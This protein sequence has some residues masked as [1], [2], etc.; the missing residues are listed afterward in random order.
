VIRLAQFSLA[1]FFAL[2][3]APASASLTERDDVRHFI[4]EMAERHGFDRSTLTD[5][6]STAEIK[7]NILEAIARPAEAKPWHQYRPI[8]LTENR[9]REGVKFWQ[10]HADVLAR[11][12]RE[13]GVAAQVIVAIIGVETFYGRHSG[14]HRVLDALSTLAFGYP[15]R[16]TFFRGQLEEFL[17]MAREEK[18][19]PREFKGSYAGAMG[20]PQFI[21]SSFRAYAVDF[22]GDGRRDLWNN[23][24]DIV[25]SVAS[26]FSRH[27]W[28]H[29]APVASRASVAGDAYRALL[30]KGVKP[31][32]TV[33]ELQRLGVTPR[34][35][36]APDTGAALLALEL[37]QGHEHWV[38]FENFYVI[39][40]YNR[41]PLYA[42]AVYQLSE[43]IRTTRAAA[44]DTGRGG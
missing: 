26:Y 5:L 34:A 19:D 44:D 41:S 18:A 28:Q 2:A 43:A 36:F 9:I 1:L 23:V 17:L 14:S 6:F 35:E 3:A 7:D 24:D 11:A 22:D 32:T 38:A 15:P 31:S 13:Y 20:Q 42:M 8:F 16:A 39:T 25:G 12:E 37:E 40:R 30:D 21:P 10:R 33:G 4:A 29:G 27:H